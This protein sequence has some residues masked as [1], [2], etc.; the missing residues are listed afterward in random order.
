MRLGRPW[1]LALFF[2]LAHLDWPSAA[3]GLDATS[4]LRW[5]LAHFHA[6]GLDPGV[7][8][9]SGY[10]PLAFVFEGALDP[11]H[12][13]GLIVARVFLA[14]MLC[15][16]IAARAW[17]ATNG[18]WARVLF[19][20]V[21][22]VLLRD[23]SLRLLAALWLW[24]WSSTRREPTPGDLSLGTAVCASSGLVDLGLFVCSSACMLTHVWICRSQK[25]LLWFAATVAVWFALAFAV[26]SPP[27]VLLAWLRNGWEFQAADR[28][29]RAV[30]PPAQRLWLAVLFAL[31][32]AVCWRGAGLHAR[33]RAT[34]PLAIFGAVLLWYQARGLFVPQ[35]SPAGYFPSACLL[36]LAAAQDWPKHVAARALA[37]ATLLWA[38]AWFLCARLPDGSGPGP[39]APTALLAGWKA[40]LG[41]LIRLPRYLREQSVALQARRAELASPALKSLVGD[42]LVDVVDGN[43]MWPA[44]QGLH[45]RPRPVFQAE[46]A[47]TLKLQHANLAALSPGRGPRWVIFP[48]ENWLNAQSLGADGE[49]MR[50]FARDFEVR[51]Q[52]ENVTL[53]ERSLAETVAPRAPRVV[54]ETRLDAGQ[55][56]TLPELAKEQLLV[57]LDVQPTL[58]GRLQRALFALPMP[59]LVLCKEGEEIV[60][61]RIDPQASIQGVLIDPLLVNG[62]DWE[63]WLGGAE[64]RRTL[65][66]E[67]WPTAG[68]PDQAKVRILAVDDFVSRSKQ[69]TPLELTARFDPPPDQVAGFAPAKLL[70]YGPRQLLCVTPPGRMVWQRGAGRVRLGGGFGLLPASLAGPGAVDAKACFR[71]LRVEAQ[72]APELVFERFLVPAARPEDARLQELDLEIVLQQPGRIV[73]ESYALGDIP[74]AGAYWLDLK[75]ES[76]P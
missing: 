75:L 5:A 10:G 16:A 13:H 37:V 67:W 72:A 17:C 2:W 29:L 63:R 19:V 40:G 53:L 48:V 21:W 71:V 73:L 20:L 36:A 25:A 61:I 44:F 45:W 30:S 74:Q 34:W 57:C 70:H 9:I 60:R 1:L 76:L 23:G 35:S 28:A 47:L 49:W 56:V 55:G 31:A 14:G 38:A 46:R 24:A 4:A 18:R 50:Q 65:W 39:A 6:Q 41:R 32:A 11:Q 3:L 66:L 33:R 52:G 8:W 15:A 22:I 27:D 69:F 58:A 51:F 42:D 12:P 62:A 7:D 26:G 68:W 43:A 59:E 64:P 54:L